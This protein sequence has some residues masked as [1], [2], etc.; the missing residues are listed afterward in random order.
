[1]QDQVL[2]VGLIGLG[3]MGRNHLRVLS[4]LKGFEL[5]FVADANAEVAA[6]TGETHGIPGV[7]D[8]TP[9]LAGV[10]AVVI[11]TPTDTHADLIE[12]FVK[13]GKAVFC[14]KPIDLSLERVKSCLGVVRAHKGTLM[15]GFNR[16]FDPHFRAVRGQIDNGA[17]G[18]VDPQAV[19]A[20]VTFLADDLLEGRD[21]GSRG[22]DIAANYVA[23]Q[24]IAMGL[25]PERG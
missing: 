6:K 11:C 25:K 21:T 10:D 15:V 3:N 9:L 5:A 19:R 22:Y 4:M 1:M 7:V 2:K 8:P 12:Q 17:I 14:E 20:H 24:F 18:D 23:A 13:A 16:R